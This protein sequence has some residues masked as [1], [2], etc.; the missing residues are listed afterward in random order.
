MRSEW[1]I[2]HQMSLAVWSSAT[3]DNKVR[4]AGLKPPPYASTMRGTKPKPCSEHFL[5][6]FRMPELHAKSKAIGLE[7]PL[8]R[9]PLL[10]GEGQRLGKGGC[11]GELSRE[12]LRHWAAWA[13]STCEGEAK[14]QIT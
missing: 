8:A 6:S 7:F 11:I 12:L 1:P 9:K 3:R 13:R 2:G 14:A 4:K 10:P 5:A